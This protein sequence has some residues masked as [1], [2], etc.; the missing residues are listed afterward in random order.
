MG[1][2]PVRGARR[3]PVSGFTSLVTF[4]GAVLGAASGTD[5]VLENS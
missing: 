2:L 4:A 1:G 3:A 5:K